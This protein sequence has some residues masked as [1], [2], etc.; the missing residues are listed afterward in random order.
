MNYYEF[1]STSIF[2]AAKA[3]VALRP[4]VFI[5]V[6]ALNGYLETLE[7]P[8]ARWV[9]QFTFRPMNDDD[10]SELEGFFAA[11]RGQAN[12]VIMPHPKKKQLRGTM[13]GSPQVAVAVS[14]LEEAIIIS[15][16]TQANKT[17]ERGDVFRVDNQLYMVTEQLVLD[18]SGSG[19]VHVSPP[20]RTP[21]TVGA[22]LTIE[23][24]TATFMLGQTEVP[25]PWEPGVSPSF[26]VTFVETFG[27]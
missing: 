8:G 27:T 23:R 6:S 10:R 24:P 15:N 2:S 11:V 20:C 12:R 18:G 13:R 14:Q 4:N 21:H 26:D 19:T 17:I 1:P 25:I 3:S 22:A 5:Q 16:P 9:V 7:L